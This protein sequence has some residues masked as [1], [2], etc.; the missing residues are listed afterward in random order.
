MENRYG[1]IP[2]LG[3][4]LMRLPMIGE[5][6]DMEQTKQMVDMFL[7]AGF[8]YFDTAWMYCGFKSENA[9]KEALVK[10]HSRDS[11]TLADKLHGGIF[12]TQ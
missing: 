4:G 1:N 8:T 2:K 9:T 12:L 3:F 11:F 5:D 10:R 6:V 7:E